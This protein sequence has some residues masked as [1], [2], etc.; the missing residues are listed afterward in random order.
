MKKKLIAVCILLG[1]GSCYA[2]VPAPYI[3]NY[4]PSST[5][6]EV[7]DDDLIHISFRHHQNTQGSTAIPHTEMVFKTDYTGPALYEPNADGFRTQALSV[8]I[9]RENGCLSVVELQHNNQQSA[10]ICPAIYDQTWHGASVQNLGIHSVYGLGQ[11]FAPIDPNR[12]AQVNGEWLGTGGFGTPDDRGNTFS[13]ITY[14][15]GAY[16]GA[17]TPRL[18]FPVLYAVGEQ[19]N[20]AL[21]LDSKLKNSFDLSKPW[22]E[23][24]NKTAPETNLYY[25]SGPDLPDLRRDFMEL[26]GRPPVPP[27]KALGL[28]ISEFSFDNWSE[29]DETIQTLRQHHFPIDGALL[30]VAWF[31]FKHAWQNN[32]EANPMGDLRFDEQA[33]PNPAAKV[34]SLKQNGIGLITIEESYVSKQGNYHGENYN[35]MAAQN[36]FA[37]DCGSNNFTEFNN[38]FGV[39]GMIDWSNTTGAAWWHD[40]VRKPNIVDLGILGHWTDLGEPEDYRAYSCYQAGDH[41]QYNNVHNLLWSKSIYDGYVRNHD[42]NPQRPYSIA[43]AGT[44]GSQR[45]GAGLWSGD[46]GGRLDHMNLHYNAAMQM[47][48]AGIDYYSSDVGGF[49]RKGDDK[50]NRDTAI[51][52]GTG[53]SE[54]EMYS[55]WFANAA[56]LDI[57]LRPHGNNCGMPG[58]TGNDCIVTETSPAMIGN[59]AGNLSNLRQRYELIPYYYSLA[60]RAYQYGEPVITPMPFYYQD[61]LHLKGM[62]DQKMIGRDI[63]V[64]GLTTQFAESRDVYLPAGTWYNYHTGEKY[65]SVSGVTLPQVNQWIAAENRNRVP[66]YARAGAIIPMMYVDEQ[67]KDVFGHRQDGS[68]RNELIVKVFPSESASIFTL[69]EDDGSTVETYDAQSRPHYQVRETLLSQNPVSSGVEILIHAAQ[70]TYAGASSERNN[71]VRT[72]VAV[73]E[74]VAVTLNGEP[75]PMLADR[76]ALESTG[77]KGWIREGNL[78]SVRTGVASVDADKKLVITSEPCSSDCGFTANLPSLMIRGTNNGWGTTDMALIADHTWQ[79]E[80]TFGAEADARF[81]FDVFGDWRQNYGDDDA[82]GQLEA[83]GA[84]IAITQGAGSYRITLFDDRNTYSITKL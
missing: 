46:I 10:T 81:K 26:V 1:S 66:A 14:T 69:Y 42:Q 82:D 47:S 37:K 33:F 23:I 39:S 80:T 38:W 17:T 35:G 67:T 9:D 49:W 19:M 74:K 78:I 40:H 71:E 28:W 59:T 58:A 57:P 51:A 64:A 54:D 6:V 22:W 25:M 2:D 31:G 73:T 75:L 11:T 30:D 56:W 61:D 7:L 76:Q 77:S 5:V 65:Q 4:G 24:R 27:K 15:D 34:A 48:F 72:L 84:D 45:Y 50:G 18:Q 3:V 53:Y 68:T 44:I 41:A 55:L 79:V 29:L 60:H 8:R 21:M 52:P 62:A 63:L 12:G 83:S 32:S 70:G 20:Y 36:G 13:S 43:R 16:A